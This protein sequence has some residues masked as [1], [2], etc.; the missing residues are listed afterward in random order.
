MW[1]PLSAETVNCF[2]TRL[3]RFW[4]HQDI[5]YNLTDAMHTAGRVHTQRNSMHTAGRMHTA[6]RYAHGRPYA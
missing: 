3:D 1:C 4:L 6:V 2:K 5:I